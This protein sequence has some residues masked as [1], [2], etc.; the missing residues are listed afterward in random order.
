M[1]GLFARHEPVEIDEIRKA[2]RDLLTHKTRGRMF[3]NIADG[4]VKGTGLEV[5]ISGV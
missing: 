2:L 4:I 3:I 5:S 1:S